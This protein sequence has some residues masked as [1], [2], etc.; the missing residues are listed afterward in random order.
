MPIFESGEPITQEELKRQ[1]AALNEKVRR[2]EFAES[3]DNMVTETFG[4]DGGDYWE[5][6]DEV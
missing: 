2:K 5:V 1:Q 4:H 6:E 3:Y